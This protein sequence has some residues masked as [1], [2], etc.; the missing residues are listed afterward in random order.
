MPDTQI[1]KHPLSINEDAHYQPLTLSQEGI[2]VPQDSS[3]GNDCLSLLALLDSHT[4]RGDQRKLSQTFARLVLGL[5]DSPLLS[6]VFVS[7]AGE[8]G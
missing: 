1:K 5:P 6:I 3:W 8:G 2:S 7:T 4:A